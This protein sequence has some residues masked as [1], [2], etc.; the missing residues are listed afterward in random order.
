MTSVN[1]ILLN[2]NWKQTVILCYA[3]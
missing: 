1:N 3:K 2:H